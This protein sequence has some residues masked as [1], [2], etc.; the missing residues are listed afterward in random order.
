MSSCP[1][2]YFSGPLGNNNLIPARPGAFLLE[3]YGGIGTSWAQTQAAV[4]QRQQDIGRK[5]DGIGFHYGAN[6]AGAA[7]TA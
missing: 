5:F 7:S 2:S 1:A 3:E 4:L 6:T